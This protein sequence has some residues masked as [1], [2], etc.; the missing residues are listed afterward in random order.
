MASEADLIFGRLAIKHGIIDEPELV[1]AIRV[2][3]DLQEA[4]IAKSVSEILEERGVMSPEQVQKIVSMQKYTLVRDEDKRYGELAIRRG[5]CS[6]ADIQEALAVQQNAI[7]KKAPTVPRLGN[8]LRD[9]GKISPDQHEELKKEQVRL[10]KPASLLESTAPGAIPAVLSGKPGAARQLTCALCGNNEKPGTTKCSVCGTD[11]S[12][13]HKAADV[14][15]AEM[16]REDAD[17]EASMFG[18]VAAE[19]GLINETQ[20][21]ECLAIQRNLKARGVSKR[22]GDIMVAKSYLTRAQVERVVSAQMTKRG[23]FVLDV[24]APKKSAKPILAVSGDKALMAAV[25][26][27]RV[28]GRPAPGLPS[29]NAPE[30][31]SPVGQFRAKNKTLIY[32]ITGVGVVVGIVVI[33]MAYSFLSGRSGQSGTSDG[34]SAKESPEEYEKK[35]ERALGKAQDLESAQTT[36]T[37]ITAIIDEYDEVATDYPETPAG[38][39]AI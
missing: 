22:M 18:N 14:A 8:I 24:A 11:F 32:A 30:A 1:E 34:G 3:G 21:D 9:R 23:E 39:K 29:R 6:V 15:A 26:A 4:G 27:P 33:Y 7:A 28:P 5:F 37:N 16:M 25:T 10:G 31:V 35:A 17:S 13:G 2:Q 19:M 20:A 12:G 38:K 36:S